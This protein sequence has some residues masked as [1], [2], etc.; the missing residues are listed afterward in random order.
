MLT[1]LLAPCPPYPTLPAWSAMT[2][3][4]SAAVHVKLAPWQEAAGG[5]QPWGRNGKQMLTD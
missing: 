3:Q 4:H 2:L 1:L 5:E